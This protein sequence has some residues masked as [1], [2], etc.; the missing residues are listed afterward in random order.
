MTRLRRISCSLLLIYGAALLYWMFIG[1]GRSAQAGGA[2]K[3]NLIPLQTIGFYLD[4]GN[5]LSFMDRVINLAGNIGV[6]IPL[7]Y[8]L[9]LS[10]PRLNSLSNLA[11]FAV[12]S[13][14][15]LELLQMLLRA[16]SFDI[17]DLLLNLL[18][19]W[20]GCCLLRIIKMIRTKEN[21]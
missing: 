8:L 18:G 9:P 21:E 6:F 2:L 5:S 16:G 11:L 3:Y 4:S 20:A 17:D 1:F 13:I 14:L 15:L 7:G 19:I 12:P 10:S